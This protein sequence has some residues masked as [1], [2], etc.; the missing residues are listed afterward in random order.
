MYSTVQYCTKKAPPAPPDH[1]QP[2]IAAAARRIDA[3]ETTFDGPIAHINNATTNGTNGNP[4]RPPRHA[5]TG[6]ITLPAGATIVPGDMPPRY[7]SRPSSPLPPPPP[8]LPMPT[9]APL[10]IASVAHSPLHSAQGIFSGS[11]GVIAFLHLVINIIELF[12][13]I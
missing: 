8:A 13:A 3:M 5:A 7:Y 1:P 6:G 10:P 4:R 11:S 9:A 12:V 2:R